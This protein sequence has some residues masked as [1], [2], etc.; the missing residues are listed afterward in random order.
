MGSNRSGVRRTARMKRHKQLQ[1]RLAAKAA[2][3]EAPKTEGLAAKVKGLAKSAVEK[4][5]GV[6]HAAVEK[7]KGTGK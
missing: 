2:A 4:V 5:E 7:I 3:S 6:L 1:N